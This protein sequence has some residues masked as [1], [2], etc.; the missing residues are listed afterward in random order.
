MNSSFLGGV[1]SQSL[2]IVSLFDTPGHR[3]SAEPPARG[4]ATAQGEFTHTAQPQ[5]GVGR[6][7]HKEPV[8][9][10]V[11]VVRGCGRGRTRS[12]GRGPLE[13]ALPAETG[14][15]WEVAAAPPQR[16]GRWRR[17]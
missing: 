16:L 4:S 5:S 17:R 13:V 14:C 10:L 9:S 6:E 1:S 12:E 3:N 11:G 15:E 2:G 8:T 7:S